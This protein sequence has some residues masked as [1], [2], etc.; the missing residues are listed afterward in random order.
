MVLQVSRFWQIFILIWF[1][2]RSSWSWF[3]WHCIWSMLDF[4][5][6]RI[7]VSGSKLARK[8]LTTVS[9][10]SPESWRLLPSCR[11][12]ITNHWMTSYHI[13]TRF[14]TQMCLILK[15]LF[16]LVSA[17]YSVT[18][19]FTHTQYVHTSEFRVCHTVLSV[20]GVSIRGV[21]SKHARNLF[22]KLWNIPGD[23]L[24]VGT[25]YVFGVL[26]MYSV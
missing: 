15:C 13:Q 18:L 21:C 9:T 24:L 6:M 17:Y 5:W 10:W 7:L 12:I 20:V 3:L 16:K 4:H 26:P 8:E 11:N 25:N 22:Q 19:K 14:S 2:K 23:R 1:T